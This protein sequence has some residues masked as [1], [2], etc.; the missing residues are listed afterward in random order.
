MNSSNQPP[1]L[2]PTQRKVVGSAITYIAGVVLALL[3]LATLFILKEFVTYFS[4]VLWPLVFATVLALLLQP[5]V[6][7]FQKTLKLRRT[8]AIALLYGL[9]LLFTAALL[10]LV[11]PIF[12]TQLIAFI[13]FIPR[14]VGKLET[15]IT[16]HFETLGSWINANTTEIQQAFSQPFTLLKRISAASLPLLKEARD[17]ARSAITLITGL[18]IIPVYLFYFLGAQLNVA[19]RLRNHLDFL[20]ESLRNDIFFLV[21]EFLNIL[22]AFF[23]GQILIGLIMGLCFAT[24]FTLVGVAFGFTLGL[25]LG[26]LNIIPYLGTILGLSTV[27]PIAYFQADE[28]GLMR[29]GLAI[30][31]FACVQIIEG[32]FL[33]PRIMGKKTGLHPVAIIVSIFFWGTALNGLLGMVLAIPLTAFLIV[34]WRLLK[35]NYLPQAEK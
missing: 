31:V 5:V 23:R 29:V 27:L 9:G 7:F 30:I 4:T 32:Y 15:F 34:A 14:L 11:L 28:G 6:L 35:K 33:T 21:N 22:V 3:A 18:A 2:T 26:M 10:A 13:E 17:T 1:L 19:E 20:K 16:S 8:A 12:I 24:G 25:M